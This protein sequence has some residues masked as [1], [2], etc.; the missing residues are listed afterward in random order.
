ALSS[1]AIQRAHAGERVCVFDLDLDSP[2]VG[3]LLS[4][5][6]EGLTSQW[7]VVDYL[8]EQATGQLQL[9]EYFHRCDRLAGAGEIIV[10]GAGVV[11]DLYPTKLARVNLEESAPIDEVGLGRLLLQ[12]RDELKPHWILLDARTGI[13]ESAGRLLSGM[14]HLHV[15]LGTTQN[16]S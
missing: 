11:D 16:Q 8:L 4:A 15:L 3:N 5:D 10:F 6:L 9:S 14:A 2:G 7:G 1:F 13:S 12:A